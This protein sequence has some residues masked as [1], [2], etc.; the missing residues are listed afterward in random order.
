MATII[1]RARIARQHSVESAKHAIGLSFLAILKNA[2]VKAERDD[3]RFYRVASPLIDDHPPM[4]RPFIHAPALG[5]L[6]RFDGIRA[7]YMPLILVDRFV[8]GPHFDPTERSPSLLLMKYAACVN[9][10]YAE[11]SRSVWT[12]I[13]LGQE[14][15]RHDGRFSECNHLGSSDWKGGYHPW[16]IDEMPKP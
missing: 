12:L 4:A 9:G 6:P 8:I 3:L 7:E 15:E 1:E 13:E 14:M 11:G 2:G 16:Q 5:L 10:F